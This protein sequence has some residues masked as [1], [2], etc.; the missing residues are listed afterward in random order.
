MNSGSNIPGYTGFIPYKQEFFG[1]TTCYAN[2]A[3]ETVYRSHKL[4]SGSLEDLRAAERTIVDIQSGPVLQ[5]STSVNNA[6][7]A[8]QKTLMNGNRSKDAKTWMNGPTHM[9]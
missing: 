5:R 9:I 1:N 2:R 3:A 7:E 4:H 6:A 8:N